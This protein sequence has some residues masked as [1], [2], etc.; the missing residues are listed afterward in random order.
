MK[1]V[2]VLIPSYEP[3]IDFLKFLKELKVEF[4]NIVVVN[5]G[6]GKKYKKIFEQIKENNITVIENFVNMGKGR[7]LKNGINYILQKYNEDNIIVTADSDGQH[8]VSDIKK[9][10]EQCA[11]FPQKLI[12]GC[13]NFDN[14]NVPYKSKFGNKLTRN[15][16]KL[17]VGL[18]ITDTQ[19][20]LRAFSCKTAKKFLTI[21]GERF[22]YETNMLI[23]TKKDKIDID[24]IEISTVYINENK[25]THFNPLKDSI[26]IYKLFFKYIFASISSFLID[27]LLFTVMY[28][29]L[30]GVINKEAILVSTVIARIISSIYNY[31]VNS[32][33]VFEQEK[34]M[35]KQFVKYY[36]LVIIQMCIS[37]LSVYIINNIINFNATFIK[38][39]ID[40]I[41]F[42]VNFCLQREWVFKEKRK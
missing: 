6:S 20:G 33:L 18:N 40:T 8:L 17:F 37:G 38:I 36:T 21:S 34:L 16:F 14:E 42:M 9:C 26:N 41:I 28:N 32:K 7:A 13:R 24:E 10:A 39:I 30:V 27:I 31:C 35:K 2:I 1:N 29:L 15:M 4:E 5:D 3:Q 12:L 25:S 22:E 11:K 19:T 23:A